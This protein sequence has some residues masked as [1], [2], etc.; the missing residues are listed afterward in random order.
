MCS[1]DHTTRVLHNH[2]VLPPAFDALHNFFQ[3]RSCMHMSIVGSAIQHLKL[4]KIAVHEVICHR[5]QNL[6]AQLAAGVCLTKL[7]AFEASYI[8]NVWN[9][10]LQHFYC[11]ESLESGAF[12]VILVQLEKTFQV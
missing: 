1:A 5:S 7:C 11:S 10:P 4:N 9:M 8:R 2:P 3:Q 6:T 12:G